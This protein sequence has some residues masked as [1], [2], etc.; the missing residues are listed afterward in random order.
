MEVRF[1]FA[2]KAFISYEFK[3]IILNFSYL[4]S[5]YE[6]FELSAYSSSG[7]KGKQYISRV[8]FSVAQMDNYSVSL[9]SNFTLCYKFNLI[10][11]L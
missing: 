1:R 5:F 4:F 6:E 8:T 11:L 2:W 9:S 7:Q 3:L 10:Y